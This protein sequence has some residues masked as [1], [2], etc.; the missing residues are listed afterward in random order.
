M[1]RIATTSILSLALTLAACA[2]QQR[3]TEPPPLTVVPQAAMEAEVPQAPP[4][5]PTGA[6][7]LAEQ[8][9]EVQAAINWSYPVSMDGVGLA[10]RLS[11]G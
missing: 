4:P 10:V 5:P 1:K 9:A 8:P 11:V 6:E 2:S 3:K 7:L